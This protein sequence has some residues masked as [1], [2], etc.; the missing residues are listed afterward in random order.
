MPLPPAL[1]TQLR[2]S[3]VLWLGFVLPSLLIALQPNALAQFGWQQTALSTR[4]W[5]LFTAHFTHLS[6]QH[7]AGNLAACFALCFIAVRLAQLIQP[8][9]LR[10]HLWPTIALSILTIDAGL[11]IGWWNMHWYAGLSGVLYGFFTAL[12]IQLCLLPTSRAWGT[13]LLLAT[14]GKIIL[15]LA[16]GTGAI[17]TLGIPVAPAAHLYGFLAALLSSLL[18]WLYQCRQRHSC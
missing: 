1:F 12:T 16:H 17:G 6:F 7:L 15:D 18:Q 9:T 3:T 2:Q 5:M 11:Y 13:I 4:P 10:L 14:A 8:P